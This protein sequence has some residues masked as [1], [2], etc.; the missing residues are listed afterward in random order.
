MGG[1]SDE[2]ATFNNNFNITSINGHIL[3][4]RARLETFSRRDAKS[5]ADLF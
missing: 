5:F 1:Y 4:T 2:K 3:C